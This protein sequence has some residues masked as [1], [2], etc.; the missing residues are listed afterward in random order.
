M[1]VN[2]INLNRTNVPG[3]GRGDY[4]DGEVVDVEDTNPALPVVIQRKPE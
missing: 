1:N 4:I 2:G 3:A